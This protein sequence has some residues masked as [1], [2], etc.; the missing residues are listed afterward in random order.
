MKQDLDALSTVQLLRL[1]Q[2]QKQ[3]Q[4]Q[5]FPQQSNSKIEM[6]TA[7]QSFL[8][9]LGQAGLFNTS[10]VV[11]LSG[12]Q[13]AKDAPRDEAH[14]SSRQ[15]P[16]GEKRSQVSID[17]LL[18]GGGDVQSQTESE[19]KQQHNLSDAELK[20]QK[21]K[22]EEQSM[23]L[24][25]HL[26]LLQN[27]GKSP[28]SAKDSKSRSLSPLSTKSNSA[29]CK[30]GGEGN[31]SAALVRGR[32]EGSSPPASTAS[33]TRGHTS[34]VDDLSE[35]ERS[36]RKRKL[37]D[38]TGSGRTVSKESGIEVALRK[39]IATGCKVGRGDQGG[40]GGFPDKGDDDVC[41]ESAVP[42]KFPEKV[43]EKV[44]GGERDSVK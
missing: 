32:D 44:D 7:Y 8:Q 40:E 20:Q 5:Q 27:D 3:Q 28:V 9:Q 6:H 23:L 14:P 38:D 41:K 43:H 35:S 17:S 30:V 42:G 12:M 2:Q 37:T 22:M 31:S 25:G 13:Q 11:M 24:G 10:E 18:G 26:N 34:P 21:Q 36:E 4:Q 15:E 16:D 19:Q 39:K 33:V 29:G 1:A